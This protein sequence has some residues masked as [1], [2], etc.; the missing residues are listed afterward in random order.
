MKQQNVFNIES[1]DFITSVHIKSARPVHRLYFV[2]LYIGI[3]H[4]HEWVAYQT[5]VSWQQPA[6]TKSFLNTLRALVCSISLKSRQK[7]D[8]LPWKIWFYF[9]PKA[10]SFVLQKESS[11]QS[12]S[13]VNYL[14]IP[15]PHSRTGCQVSDKGKAPEPKARGYNGNMRREEDGRAE[16]VSRGGQKTEVDF[17]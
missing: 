16:G 13:H 5:I 1:Y 10:K 14:I 11:F 15:W 6:E 9:Q 4:S 3:K 8:F 12:D 7:F 2:L 17:S